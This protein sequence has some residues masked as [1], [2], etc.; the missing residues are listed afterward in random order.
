MAAPK[1]V[2]EVTITDHF[3]S[4]RALAENP[5]VCSDIAFIEEQRL[6][7]ETVTDNTFDRNTI[8]HNCLVMVQEAIDGDDGI[9]PSRKNIELAFQDYA[10]YYYDRFNETAALCQDIHHECRALE[11]VANK[12]LMPA[13]EIRRHGGLNFV[14]AASE[15]H[16]L[17]ARPHMAQ[18]IRPIL[19][20]ISAGEMVN[21]AKTETFM[22]YDAIDGFND[23]LGS[24]DYEK[25][26]DAYDRAKRAV[27]VNVDKSVKGL[28]L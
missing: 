24:D 4:V 5:Y 2:S 1:T 21:A 26:L 6:K 12:Q 17:I 22:L 7:Y 11:A 19:A 28:T 18:A 27:E 13:G 14:S 16:A 23:W 20:A 10:E 3:E 25:T 9:I 8:I 15:I